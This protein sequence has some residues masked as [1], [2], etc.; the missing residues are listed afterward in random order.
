MTRE[1]NCTN[2]MNS[3]TNA[4]DLCWKIVTEI[5]D[6]RNIDHDKIDERLGDVIDTR[7]LGRLAAQSGDS[8][9][10]ELSVS[11]QM[12]GCFVTVTDGGEVRASCPGLVQAR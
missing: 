2:R 4:D 1:R 3:E 5:A 8:D 7:A 9:T 10:I 6:A 11:F 12:A